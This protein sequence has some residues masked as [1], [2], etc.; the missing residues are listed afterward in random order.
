[1]AGNTDSRQIELRDSVTQIA[2]GANNEVDN[3][4]VSLDYE[5]TP[6]FRIVLTSP[7][8]LTV[9]SAIITNPE[10]G[11]QRAPAPING[12]I[13]FAYTDRTI[14]LSAASLLADADVGTDATFTMPG[15]QYQRLGISVNPSTGALSLSIG[16]A[17]A[18]AGSAG[19]PAIPSGFIGIGHVLVQGNGSGG[20]ND[21]TNASIYQYESIKD[22][23]PPGAQ[24][25]FTV[26][27]ADYT[28][29]D[30]D[31]YRSIAVS[32]GGSNRT[33]TLP[34]AAN[35]TNR[36]LTILK[37][38]T[39]VG[40]VIIDGNGAELVGGVANFNLQGRYAHAEVQSDGTGWQLLSLERGIVY[41]DMVNDRVGIN[42]FSPTYA[43]DVTG[44]IR[45]T[46]QHIGH[47]SNTPAAP[48][49][50]FNG[51]LNNGM[52]YLTTNTIAWSTNGSYRAAVDGEG[53]WGINTTPLNS[54]SSRRMMYIDA[55]TTP[56]PTSSNDNI[57]L[58]VDV[59]SAS[60]PLAAAVF[61]NTF[62]AGAITEMIGGSFDVRH[63]HSSAST[64]V[65]AV[66]ARTRSTST[67][68]TITNMY[69]VRAEAGPLSSSTAVTNLYVNY[70]RALRNGSGTITNAYRYYIAADNAA[71]N[72][73][74][75]NW[76]FYDDD[77]SVDHRFQGIVLVAAGT[78]A[79]PSLV[80][81]STISQTG[82][83]APGANSLGWAVSGAAV[84]SISS[85]GLWTI[86]AS[87]SAQNH[88]VNGSATTFTQ[89]PGSGTF[90]LASGSGDGALEIRGSGAGASGGIL[91]YG[92]THATR[93]SAIYFKNN[94]NETGNI[95]SAGMW[96]I[97][98]T[99]GTQ[100]HNFNGVSTRFTHNSAAGTHLLHGATNTNAMEVRG[101]DGG[102]SAGIIYYGST[103]ATF[104]AFLHF[105]NSGV[106]TG[107]VNA[108]GLWT[109]GA[110]G[111]TQIHVMN[112][113][114]LQVVHS[115]GASAFEIY[116][117]GTAG[118]LLLSGGDS[119][120]RA[121]LSL[122]GA[123][124]TT[125]TASSAT[126]GTIS[127][128]GLWTIGTSGGA[129]S[130]VIRGDST[131]FEHSSA[132][133]QY[134]L[135]R[136]SNTGSLEVR[137]SGGGS[138]A[139][140]ILYA[141]GHSTPSITTFRN[142]SLDTGSISAA[143][144]WTIGQTN[145]AQIHRM[146][147]NALQLVRATASDDFEIYRGSA[148]GGLILAGGD[149][150]DRGRIKLASGGDTYFYSVNLATQNGS[151][152]NIGDWTIG[153]SVDNTITF[154]GAITS[155]SNA[156]IA[157]SGTPANIFSFAASTNRGE[158]YLV[159]VVDKSGGQANILLVSRPSG[160]GSY[161]TQDIINTFALAGST[162]GNAY[163]LTGTADTYTINAIRLS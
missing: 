104:A 19:A 35:N 162:S 70:A 58:F 29:L 34:L 141:A 66:F 12:A 36:I 152:S 5:V 85:A 88:I 82:M 142:S 26:S 138:S 24:T 156:T 33:I 140:I 160:G 116:R 54:A 150:G 145:N 40:E 137:G 110:S 97:G 39:G 131:Q 129:Q 74:T 118:S 153:N 42:N 133:G 17:N 73:I 113:S 132:T 121:Q 52:Y 127:A 101:S 21:L 23:T 94:S 9:Q 16:S 161:V 10:T 148:T 64:H 109:I 72:P 105:R 126:T 81:G 59:N 92:N 27:G 87:G 6:L 120:N 95:D 100:T 80:F 69:G 147:G 76:G 41:I 139:G 43:L 91:V 130:H 112:G 111:S 106:T 159:T 15:T 99:G 163:R 67:G 32:T 37:I 20:V 46:A 102:S 3:L 60:T 61:G 158:S 149:S 115:V 155:S 53:Y 84:G 154:R 56:I 151:I 71:T 93:A 45:A 2:D 79:N 50:A 8:V 55:F 1:M 114:Q 44:D 134:L 25:L 28:I 136:S 108:S 62:S 48:A 135:F 144:L 128:A 65:Q 68:V 90:L 49:Y 123:G 51:A 31:G 7:L 157:L 96:E 63:V 119:G 75:N 117:S 4:L 77:G 89:T 30:A 38:D 78:A 18:T 86:G 57:G 47:A 143:G 124:V 122:T 98:Q 125:F 22:T 146:N 83:Y 14:T 13:P 107:S 11:R 103:H